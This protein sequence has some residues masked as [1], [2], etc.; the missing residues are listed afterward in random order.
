[1]LMC[2]LLV[3]VSTITILV[4]SRSSFLEDT[5]DIMA[6]LKHTDLPKVLTMPSKMNK[7]KIHEFFGCKIRACSLP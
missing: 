2:R 7:G 1:M 4:I 6:M 3:E 5:T